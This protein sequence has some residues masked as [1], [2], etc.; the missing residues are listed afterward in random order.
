MKTNYDLLMQEEIKRLGNE[1]KKILLHSCCG[2]CSTHVIKTLLPYFDLTVFYYN[3]NIEPVEE[4]NLRKSVQMT[5]LEKLG[6]GYLDCD[7]ENDSFKKISF[8][9]ENDL[10]GGARC[11]LCFKLRLE[12]TALEAKNNNYDY[13]ATTLTVSPHKNSQVINAIG[14]SVAQN[15]DIKFLYADFKKHDGYKKS[16]ELSKEY[17]LYRQDYCGC[18]YSKNS[19]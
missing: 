2:P 18:L 9:H 1:K 5:V 12:K 7:Y 15:Y 17:N 19:T 14:A 4:Y 3:P 16:I 13:F 8:G 6:V 11:S 10:E